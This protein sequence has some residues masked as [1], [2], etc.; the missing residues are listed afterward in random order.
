MSYPLIYG[1]SVNLL[2][3]SVD[4]LWISQSRLGIA[5]SRLWITQSRLGIAQSRLGISQSRLGSSLARLGISQSRLWISLSRLGISIDRFWRA[6]DVLWRGIIPR[7]L[8]ASWIGIGCCR[9]L[10]PVLRR[11]SST[12]NALHYLTGEGEPFR[13]ILSRSISKSRANNPLFDFIRRKSLK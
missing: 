1:T 3:S 10:P 8:F 13:R 11:F 9:L 12:V 4:R 5:Q 6:A 2:R 7:L